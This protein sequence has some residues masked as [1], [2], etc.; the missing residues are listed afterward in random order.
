MVSLPLQIQEQLGEAGYRNQFR[1]RDGR[2]VCLNS[3]QSYQV[4]ELSVEATYRFEEN[5]DPDDDALLWVLKARDGT[6]G[7]FLDA[8]GVYGDPEAA[9]FIAHTADRR[10]YSDLMNRLPALRT[11]QILVTSK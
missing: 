5:S 6:G 2:M 3:G 8:H 4:G 9:A 7:V 1:F 10:R 11:F